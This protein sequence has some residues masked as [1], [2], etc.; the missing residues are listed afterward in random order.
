MFL[1]LFLV[2]PFRSFNTV[3]VFRENKLSDGLCFALKVILSSVNY[4]MVYT[5]HFQKS[6][7]VEDLLFYSKNEVIAFPKIEI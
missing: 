7:F 4:H 2:L 1:K 6:R 5:A 3:V